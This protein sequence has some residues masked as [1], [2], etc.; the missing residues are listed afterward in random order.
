[1]RAATPRLTSLDAWA[2]RAVGAAGPLDRASLEALQLRTLQE[3]VAWAAARSP[4]YRERLAAG[5]PPRLDRL[6]DLRR[7]P[8][9]TAEDVRERG[10]RLLCVSQD[11]VARVVTLPS[12]GTTG[13]PKRLAF[14]AEEQEAIVEF[15]RRGAETLVEPGERMLVLLPGGRPGSVGE[16]FAEALRRLGAIPVPHGFVTDLPAALA[17]LRDARP[18]SLLAAPVQALALARFAEAAG[19]RPR[20]RT[21][22]VSSDHASGPLVRALEE[23]FG[24]EV[25]DHYGMTEMGLGGALECDAHDGAHLREAELLFEVVDPETGAPLP[26]GARGE[27]VFTT[28][29]RRAMPLVRYRTGDLSRLLPGRCRCGSV[30]RRLERVRG[31]LAERAVVGDAAWAA[32][33]GTPALDEALF[34]VPGLA[35]YA[36]AFR[37][38]PAPAR[39]AVTAYGFGPDEARLAREVRAALARD[40]ITGPALR[41]GA[42][43]AEV[44]GARLGDR[45]LRGPGKRSLAPLGG[46]RG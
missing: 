11:E 24:C 42:L 1:M 46:D 31:R 13:A 44:T 43:V 6:E 20:L 2:A 25:F 9:T 26:D 19:E 3:T 4:L 5:G 27:V 21:A 32:G 29:A 45:L 30:L 22:L 39:L 36:A 41:D 17:A 15:F 12:S 33:L 14:A 23:A 16:L 28:L 10:S 35:D 8:V 40:P 7:L 34:A 18:A 38:S 37:A